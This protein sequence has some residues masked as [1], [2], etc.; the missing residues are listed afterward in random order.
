MSKAPIG[1][2]LDR[3]A[4]N[5]AETPEKPAVIDDRPDGFLRIVTFNELNETVNRIANALVD[6][7]VAYGTDPERVIEI[8][9]DSEP[10]T[11]PGRLLAY[12]AV[13]GGFVLAEIV[14]PRYGASGLEVD[15]DTH[16]VADAQ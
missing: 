5:A 11:R 13:T 6:V 9:C 3:L 8:L 2:T 16:V 4:V 1:E 12:H 14:R 10:R 15:A 7:G